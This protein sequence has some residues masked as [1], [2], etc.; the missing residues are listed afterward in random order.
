MNKREIVLSLLEEGQHENLPPQYIPAAFFL[1]FAPA[2]KQG[3][4]AAEKHREFFH[5]TDMDFV[6]VQYERPF[7]ARSIQRPSDWKDIPLLDTAFFEPQLEVVRSLIQSLKSEAL[8][9]VTLYSP[10]MCA[11]QISGQQTL[12]EHLQ[13]EPSVVEKGLE[14][15]TESLMVFVRECIRLGVDGFYH[16]TQGAESQRFADR[17]LFL[18]YIKP[19]DLRVMQEIER[20]CPFNI[21]HICDYHRDTY[22]GYDDLSVFLDY[23]GH[24]VN[25]SQEV[26]D[27]RLS[28]TALS[29]RFCRPF[30]GGMNRLGMLATG[31]QEQVRE[32]TQTVLRDAPARFIL[33][34]D[35]TVP[36]DTPWENLR[37]AIEEAHQTEDRL[38][39][40]S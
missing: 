28:G 18:D 21:L 20:Q 11:G 27:E 30:M 4:A 38:S 25:C 8:I 19:F 24:V 26:G 6:K 12:T 23:P 33:G 10:F 34:A 3:E 15:V 16:S 14:S 35:C 36:G 2:F 7:P 9:I 39:Y 29:D 1:H 37:A 13:A 22:G 5:F 17:S 32:E 40:T 31:T